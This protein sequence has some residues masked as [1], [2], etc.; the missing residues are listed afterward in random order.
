MIL[1]IC[2]AGASYDSV[3][4]LRGKVSPR[5]PPLASELFTPDNEIVKAAIKQFPRCYD[6]LPYLQQVPEGQT[7]E[8]KLQDMQNEAEDDPVRKQQLAAVRY[9]LQ[10]LITRFQQHWEDEHSGVTNYRTFID[11]LRRTHGSRLVCIVTFNY[12]CMI[13]EALRGSVGIKIDSLNDYIADAAFK[14]FKLHGSVNWFRTVTAPFSKVNPQREETDLIKELIQ[15]AAEIKT[16]EFR[17]RNACP[18][19]KFEDTPVWPA[20]AIPVTTKGVFECPDEHLERLKQLLPET[21]RIVTIGWR[22]A[23]RHFLDLLSA[24]LSSRQLPMLAV[25]GD[26]AGAKEVFRNFGNAGIR[27]GRFDSEDGFSNTIVA[28]TIEDFCKR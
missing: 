21:E 18:I 11:Q 19:G 8:T 23:E 16:G 28:R 13:E 12:D 10:L 9:Y 14:L 7:L 2:G 15:S 17:L 26:K 24:A 3:T 25:A 1:V 5:R 27:V 6:I 4:A 22:G 20:I